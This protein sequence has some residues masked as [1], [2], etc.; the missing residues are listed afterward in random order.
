MDLQ[1]HQRHDLALELMGH[2]HTCLLRLQT[3]TPP[4]MLRH[5]A[6]AALQHVR[7]L[8]ASLHVPSTSRTLGGT[9]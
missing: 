5:H 2:L 8:C 6:E 9:L 7:A 3:G 4:V 1:P